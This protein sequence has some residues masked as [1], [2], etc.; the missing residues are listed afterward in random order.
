M[1]V[2]RKDH[3]DPTNRCRV[4]CWKP[5][6]HCNCQSLIS[7][8]NTSGAQETMICMHIINL[9]L[10]SCLLYLRLYL[11]FIGV[12]VS[13]APSVAYLCLALLSF[14]L[15]VAMV[16]FLSSYFRWTHFFHLIFQAVT[17]P[18]WTLGG[19]TT[20]LA[21]LLVAVPVGSF[22]EIRKIKEEKTE[23]QT[24]I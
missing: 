2:C 20:Q 10:W 23:S 1:G 11:H 24:Y 7:R 21:Q 15:L 13:P 4:I 8:L 14:V 3:Q 22:S 18:I 19:K 12:L 6:P 5:F 17:L 16:S 9:C